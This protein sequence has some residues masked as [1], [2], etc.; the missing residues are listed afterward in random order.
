MTSAPGET[1]NL[2]GP[3]ARHLGR[4]GRDPHSHRPGQLARQHRNPDRGSPGQPGVRHPLLV[5]RAGH[6]P[7]PRHRSRSRPESRA[8][9]GKDRQPHPAGDAAIT[10]PAHDRTRRN[11]RWATPAGI[12]LAAF[13]GCAILLTIF[14]HAAG[15]PISAVTQHQPGHGTTLF[16]GG[17]GTRHPPR[18]PGRPHPRP[19]RPSRPRPR[20]HRPPPAGPPPPPPRPP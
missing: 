6:P 1:G 13:L 7:R 8:V 14:E 9:R 17:T 18:P 12:V 5:G 20:P 4:G 2:P 16:G 15:K 11:W 19:R 3:P 10:R